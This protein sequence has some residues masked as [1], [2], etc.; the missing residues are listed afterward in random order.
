MHSYGIMSLQLHGLAVVFDLECLEV[1]QL[2]LSWEPFFV[3]HDIE[4]DEMSF[5]ARLIEPAVLWK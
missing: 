2:N 1:Y 3:S 4:L 5:V